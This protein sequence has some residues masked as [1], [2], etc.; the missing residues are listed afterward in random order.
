[1]SISDEA[2]TV[3]KTEGDQL[4]IGFGFEKVDVNKRTVE[5]FATL[6]NID[7]ADDIVDFEASQ[8]AFSDWVGNI[9]E[10]HGPL[11]V[12]KALSIEEKTRQAEDGSYNG[13]YV[14][15]YISKGAEDTWQKILDGTLTGFS[16]GGRVLEK[17]PEVVKAEGR[18]SRKNVN[19]ITRYIL[20]ELSVVDN[21]ANP[22]ANFDRVNKADSLQ[23]V[24]YDDQNELHVTDVIEKDSVVAQEQN[25]FYCGD[26]DDATIRLS[27]DPST[28]CVSCDTPDTMLVA[29]VYETPTSDEV[30]KMVKSFLDIVNLEELLDSDPLHQ[31]EDSNQE[32]GVEAVAPIE[33]YGNVTVNKAVNN[34]HKTPPA[35]YPTSRSSY[36][37][38]ANYK[39]PLDTTVRIR[40]AM[41]YYNQSTQQSAGGYS[42]AQWVAIGRKI[43]SAANR[44]YGPGHVLRNGKIM[45]DEDTKKVTPSKDLLQNSNDDTNNDTMDKLFEDFVKAIADKIS[46]ENFAK[47][48]GGDFE[49]VDT[50]ALTNIREVLKNAFANVEEILSKAGVTSLN[51]EAATDVDHVASA[52]LPG[53][54]SNVEPQAASGNDATADVW[55]AKPGSE[56]VLPQVTKAEETPVEET[57]AEEKLEKVDE[58][59]AVE[60]EK[61]DEGE[62]IKAVIGEE[63]QK[64]SVKTVEALDSITNSMNEVAE[65]VSRLENSGASKKSGEVNEELTKSQPKSFW[66][67]AFSVNTKN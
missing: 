11:A 2:L 18:Y 9:R 48:D 8:A 40:A 12:G 50:Q 36:A 49:K 3:V 30:T 21:P 42:S 62:L 26:C 7:K 65:R 17:R 54:E 61:A 20:G 25:I 4:A 55:A 22:L 5:G 16:I 66:G 14:K 28:N 63:L 47:H 53:A 39:Y 23:L 1:M 24:K 60:A 10:M 44:A 51:S 6:D 19:R 38:P 34:A 31:K 35:G 56:N 33:V 27:T 58:T 32:V 43:I 41:A 13:M 64:F 52:S 15:A 29:V 37:D 45:I 46:E 67:G 57:S 59:P